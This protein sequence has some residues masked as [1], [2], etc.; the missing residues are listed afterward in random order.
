M[1]LSMRDRLGGRC[2]RLISGLFGLLA[3]ASVAATAVPVAAQTVLRFVP[4]ADLRSVDPVW[5]TA[6]VTRNHG[7]MI[8]D[9]LFSL[10]SKLRPQ[11]Q[12]VESWTVTPDKMQWEF[13]L[14]PGLNW[15]DGKPVTAED[16]VASI[17]RW[18]A[19]DVL[20]N[21]LLVAAETLEVVDAQRFRLTLKQPFGQVLEALAKPSN[22][23]LFMMPKRVAETDPFKQIEETIGS[24]P[25]K[26]VRAEWLPG[27]KAVYVKNTDYK[28]RSE[29][30]DFLSGGKVVK[31]DRVE[32]M[33]VP[34][35]AVAV[36]ALGAGEVDWLEVP[37]PDLV[38]IIE[39]DAAITV[40]PIDMIGSQLSIRINHLHAP[41]DNPK[42]RQALLTVIGQSDY[43][44][45]ISSDPRWVKA[46]P[47]YFGCNGTPYESLAGT[48]GHLKQ[49]DF[50]KAKRLLKEAG[51]KGER[52]VVLDP[53]DVHY[54]HAP[55]LVTAENLKKAGFNVDLQ[56]MDFGTA[57]G[58]I[59]SQA[60]L[61]QGGWSL[62]HSY[63]TIMDVLT[64][65]IAT[66][67]RA[68]GAKNA[69]YGWPTD[70]E[71]E[72]LRT[73]WLTLTDPAEQKAYA[74]KVQARA[75]EAVPYIVTG[76]LIIPTAYRKS[77]DGIV[78]SGIP[79]FWNLTKK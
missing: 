53:A 72:G 35:S 11:P 78:P 76:T 25:F 69:A 61:D 15:H 46:C 26:F 9:Q 24:G 65:A 47:G 48:E 79:V 3:V 44:N 40:R 57:I 8:Y 13:T 23:A 73:K 50:A 32:W 28:P 55:A 5:T 75:F 63:A 41:M 60:P 62:F 16:C 52:V 1:G 68:G 70:P 30:A 2:G 38:P 49:A 21:R 45:A 12:M 20:G 59:N 19:R 58:K 22:N 54:S 64:P 66:G 14:R 43:L 34:D 7:H 39:R 31:V 17:K 10:D 74:D 27:G 6:Y 67:L 71:L 36:A 4:H 33:S 37:S 51:Y 29:P 18:G 77:V 56:T 42:V